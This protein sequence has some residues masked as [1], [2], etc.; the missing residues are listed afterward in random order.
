MVLP[1]CNIW[2]SKEKN[3]L[4]RTMLN[5]HIV[6]RSFISSYAKPVLNKS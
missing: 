5:K 4:R 1:D 3:K 2:Q 6:R